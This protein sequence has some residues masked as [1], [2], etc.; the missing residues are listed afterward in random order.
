MNKENN[1]FYVPTP[2]FTKRQAFLTESFKLI[3]TFS[4]ILEFLTVFTGSYLFLKYFLNLVRLTVLFLNGKASPDLIALNLLTTTLLAGITYT[5]Y[6]L[7]NT[8]LTTLNAVNVWGHLA[9]NEHVYA[10]KKSVE[11]AID[12][13]D[14]K[15][16]IRAFKLFWLLTIIFTLI[17]ARLVISI[18]PQNTL[19]EYIPVLV[20]TFATVII[21][22]ALLNLYLQFVFD[23]VQF[24]IAEVTV[25]DKNSKK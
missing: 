20:L 17:T 3:R 19:K 21:I 8:R 10:S 13:S 23:D 5:V 14:K 9:M 18:S 6:S 24:A 7:T 25:M 15:E 2:M 22:D 11:M 16:A 1:I 12:N 4:Y